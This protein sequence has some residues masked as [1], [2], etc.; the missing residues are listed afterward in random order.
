[1]GV[2]LPAPLVTTGPTLELLKVR[3]DAS[4]IISGSEG[5]NWQQ[6]LW[7]ASIQRLNGE[8]KWNS[9]MLVDG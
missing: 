3:S 2:A 4:V 5:L 9:R 6:F 1:M 8:T 7:T